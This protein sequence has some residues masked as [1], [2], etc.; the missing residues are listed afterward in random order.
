MSSSS[1][2]SRLDS[3]QD[4]INSWAWPTKFRIEEFKWQGAHGVRTGNKFG[5]ELRL[6]SGDTRN[7]IGGFCKFKSIRVAFV[8]KYRSFHEKFYLNNLVELGK[9]YSDDDQESI[10]IVY[11]NV[12][13]APYWWACDEGGIPNESVW[14]E[15]LCR[16]IC[17]FILK[18][19]SDDIPDS[20]HEKRK[21]T[22]DRRHT[23]QDIDSENE[24]EEDNNPKKRQRKEENESSEESKENEEEHRTLDESSTEIKQELL[25]LLLDLVKDVKKNMLRVEDKVLDLKD[26]ILSMKKQLSRLERTRD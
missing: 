12:K 26:E 2:E 5:M 18:C 23:K 7:G 17:D 16:A 1:F 15:K 22:H 25:D 14:T 11:N 6:V 20:R 8:G 21:S 9:D 24:Q 10:H 13:E 19:P 4:F 3:A